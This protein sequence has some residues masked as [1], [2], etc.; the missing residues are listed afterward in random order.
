[1]EKITLRVFLACM[2]LCASGFIIVLWFEERIPEE[3]F[4]VNATFFIIGF[5][6]FIFWATRIVYRFLRK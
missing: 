4:K 6:S 3:V 5:G 2:V 1:M